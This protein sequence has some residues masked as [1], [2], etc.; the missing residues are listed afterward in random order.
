MEGVRSRFYQSVASDAA[1][2]GYGFESGVG[3]G[4][5]HDCLT[6]T[7]PIH[8]EDCIEKLIGW[9]IEYKGEITLTQM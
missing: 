3:S 6:G 5:P 1:E 4:Y 7:T 8:L 2:S 9:E